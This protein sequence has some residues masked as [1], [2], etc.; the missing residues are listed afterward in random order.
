[1]YQLFGT[2]LNKVFGILR[3]TYL[4]VFIV[5]FLFAGLNIVLAHEESS[6]EC[7]IC[8]SE[9]VISP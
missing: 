7:Y 4:K 2:T 6:D 1:M 9:T 3:F 5:L 8:Y